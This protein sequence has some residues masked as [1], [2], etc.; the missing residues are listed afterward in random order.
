MSGMPRHVAP[1]AD[2]SVSITE[3]LVNADDKTDIQGPLPRVW[4][5]HNHGIRVELDILR[6]HTHMAAKTLAVAAFGG[7]D[8]HTSKSYRNP[9]S[10]IGAHDDV[11]GVDIERVETYDKTFAESICMP[12]E[13]V[14]EATRPRT[15]RQVADVWSSKEAL[16]KALGDALDYDPRRL[17]GLALAPKGRAG[18]WQ[19]ARVS[20]PHGHVGWVVWRIPVESKT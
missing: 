20:V 10:L 9:L 2:V 14:S 19:A 4:L 3:C 1:G 5:A 15:G 11:V 7:R 13:W 6:A 12:E 8:C 17:V 16:A 18:R